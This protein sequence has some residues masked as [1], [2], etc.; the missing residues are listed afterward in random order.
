LEELDLV[1]RTSGKRTTTL[2]IVSDRL[3]DTIIPAFPNVKVIRTPGGDLHLEK[4]GWKCYAT[5]LFETW[6][7]LFFS[8]AFKEVFPQI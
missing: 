4:G 2:D 7:E 8:K 6:D 1:F 3:E 5:S